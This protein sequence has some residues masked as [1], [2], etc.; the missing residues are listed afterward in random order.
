MTKL[1]AAV[2][3]VLFASRLWTGQVQAPEAT[4]RARP[5]IGSGP[6]QTDNGTG[7]IPKFYSHPR[8]VLVT[9]TVWKHAARSAAWVPKEVLQ[10]YPTAAVGI[11]AT[12]PV[13]RGL[14]ANDFRIFDNGTEQKINYLEESDFSPRD[15]NGQWSFAADVRGSWGWL[16]SADLA[17]AAPTATYVI[18]YIPPPLQSGDCHTIR[19]LAGGNDVDLNR[20]R[21]CN[22]DEG[23]TATAKEK[24]T[25]CSDGP[26]CQVCQTWINQ[27]IE[28]AI[29][30]LVLTCFV[31]HEG[32]PGT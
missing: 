11:L 22:S 2:A 16:N 30:V 17:L 26:L 9:A 8:Q 27:G 32:W 7:K 25:R 23:D 4:V 15:I 5:L 14:S 18:G 19:V 1:V 10:R 6:P 24:K 12:P 29:R 31:P 28:P 3:F 13:A 20:T 21:Y